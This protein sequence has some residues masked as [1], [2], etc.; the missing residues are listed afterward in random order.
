MISR[1][2]SLDDV[3]DAFAAVSSGVVMRQVIT[4]V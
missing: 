3:Y 4:F 1:R 2:L